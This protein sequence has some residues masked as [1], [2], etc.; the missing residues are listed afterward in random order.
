MKKTFKKPLLLALPVLVLGA[1]MLT[2]KPPAPQTLEFDIGGGMGDLVLTSDGR[3]IVR[4]GVNQVGVIEFYDRKKG[5]FGSQN[6]RNR[7]MTGAGSASPV[8][9][10]QTTY[11]AGIGGFISDS[12]NS[13]GIYNLLSDSDFRSI[14]AYE[15]VGRRILSLPDGQT[16]LT[17]DTRGDL[18]FRD[19]QSG[20]IKRRLQG[21]SGQYTPLAMALSGDVRILATAGE[22]VSYRIG[23]GPSLGKLPHLWDLQTGKKIRTLTQPVFPPSRGGIG[24]NHLDPT[25]LSFSPDDRFLATGSNGYGVVIW[26]VQT[27]AVFRLLQ[28]PENRTGNSITHMSNGGDAVFSPDSK[29]I[30]APG[31]YG[32]IDVYAVSSGKLLRQIKGGGPLLWSKEG[33][34]YRGPR[35]SKNQELLT[36]IKL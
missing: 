2:I 7:G 3:F 35:N 28:H 15:V 12:P 18:C 5:V 24:W 33:L 30:A 29:R 23:A 21:L 34:F 6:L 27:G 16:L 20:K 11:V 17:F 1:A 4:G 13:I 32:T 36:Q 31:N 22:Y 14:A 8:V 25:A 26:N 19:V 9:L 10:G